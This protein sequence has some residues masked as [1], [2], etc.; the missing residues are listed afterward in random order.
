MSEQTK[1]GND[2]VVPTGQVPSSI[3]LSPTTSMDLSW[4][5]EDQRAAL[6]Q[7]HARGM[8]DISRRAQE[9]HVD[10]ATLEGTLNQLAETTRQVSEAG[11]SIT[12]THTQ[13]TKIGRTE[14]SMGNTAAA[15]SGRL[16]SSQ[17]GQRDWTPFYVAGGLVALVLIAALLGS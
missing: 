13:T 11:D 8:L 16:S 2:V 14:I 10:V 1:L 6:L 5:P 15:Q 12:I 3:M 7:E 4:L 9:L 17:T